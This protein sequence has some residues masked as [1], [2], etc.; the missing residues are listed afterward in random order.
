[1]EA[2]LDLGPAG[3]RMAWTVVAGAARV[4]G[5]AFPVCD[6]PSGPRAAHLLSRAARR[7]DGAA[8]SPAVVFSTSLLVQPDRSAVSR[9]RCRALP[10]VRRRLAAAKMASRGTALA[11]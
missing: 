1:M 7:P 6:L 3:V 11:T 9:S 4:R 5:S 2:D 8:E 10:R